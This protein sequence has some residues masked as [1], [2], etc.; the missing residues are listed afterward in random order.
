MKRLF[1]FASAVALVGMTATA[2]DAASATSTVNVTATVSATA[3]LS[4]S[5]AAIS[6][7]DA[8]PDSTPSIPGS[9]VIT[10]TA[11]GKAQTGNTITLTVQ[12]SDDLKSGGDTIPIANISWTAGGDTGYVAGTMSKSSAVT[13]GSWGQSGA[14]NGTQSYA[15]ANSWNYKTGSYATSVT[16]TLT[17]L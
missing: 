15:L 16:Y 14:Y 2:A 11:K 4:L 6:F 8:D 12:A 9:A 7:P 17:A 5:E 10:I 3:K 1:Q 13:L